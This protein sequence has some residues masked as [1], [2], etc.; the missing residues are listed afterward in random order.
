MTDTLAK[1]ALGFTVS[2]AASSLV[3]WVR[4]TIEV[5]SE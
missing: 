2:F 5:F 1:L 4:L 3:A